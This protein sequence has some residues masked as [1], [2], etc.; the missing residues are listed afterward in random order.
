MAFSFI[1]FQFHTPSY[2]FPFPFIIPIPNI[3]LIF[4]LFLLLIPIFLHLTEIPHKRLFLSL[5]P[6]SCLSSTHPLS[7]F[8]SSYSNSTHPFFFFL[9]FFH[10]IPISHTLSFL[11]FLHFIPIPHTLFFYGIFFYFSST[12]PPILSPFPSSK[13]NFTH[14]YFISVFSPSN[15]KSTPYFSYAF[16]YILF[17][18]LTPFFSVT[19]S[20]ILFQFH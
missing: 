15:L 7:L 17:Q 8:C 13:S 4:L 19:F 9:L 5:F 3:L 14:H 2:S 20:F 11:F 16:P 12:H 1:L 18:F 10:L 6:S